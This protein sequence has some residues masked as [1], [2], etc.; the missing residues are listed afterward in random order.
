MKTIKVYSGESIIPTYA[1]LHPVKAVELGIKLI[2]ELETETSISTNNTDLISTIKYVGEKN[3]IET[4][5]YLDDVCY[6]NDI[7]PLFGSFNKSMDLIN[8]HSENSDSD[9]F[10]KLV[11][12]GKYLIS[13]VANK[14]SVNKWNTKTLEDAEKSIQLY[15]KM[16]PNLNRTEAKI[17]EI[18]SVKINKVGGKKIEKF[19]SELIKKIDL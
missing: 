7:E 16:N 2:N 14:N 5:F 10:S 13:I 11:G 4:I 3:G 15:I 6:N 18:I 17:Y 12:E 19:E 9:N 8:E 1:E